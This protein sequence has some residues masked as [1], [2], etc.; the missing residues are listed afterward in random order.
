MPWA[1]AVWERQKWL[2]TG[3][4]ASEGEEGQQPA[5]GPMSFL[6]TS[7]GTQLCSGPS[8]SPHAALP[9]SAHHCHPTALLFP[10][11]AV[12]DSQSGWVG[13]DLNECLAPTSTGR[14][15]NH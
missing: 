7:S 1:L 6:Y 3:H 5:A 13:K 12:G 11:D 15:V 8:T 4:G 2:C 9:R 14:V 10:S